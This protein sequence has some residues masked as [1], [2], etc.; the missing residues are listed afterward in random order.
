MSGFNLYFTTCIYQ[1][2]A[3]LF[4]WPMLLV[5]PQTSFHGSMQQSALYCTEIQ[6][7]VL[8]RS[9]AVNIPF[10][11]TTF[12]EDTVNIL[13][14][15]IAVN[16]A[17]L[18]TTLNDIF[19]QLTDVWYILQTHCSLRTISWLPFTD[20]LHCQG[21]YCTLYP[22]TCIISKNLAVSKLENENATILCLLFHCQQ[23]L[24]YSAYP[25]HC[26]QQSVSQSV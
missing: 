21:H 4:V 16:I 22:L 24:V 26:A 10:V 5:G 14:Q 8:F 11:L 2:V 1:Y 23:K 13:V 3:S 6:W 12:K 7:H 20:H 15:C 25:V 9:T 18:L 19:C 17:F